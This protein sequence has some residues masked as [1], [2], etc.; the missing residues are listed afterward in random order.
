VVLRALLTSEIGSSR[1]YTA[2]QSVRFAFSACSR[3]FPTVLPERRRAGLAA[4]PAFISCDARTSYFFETEMLVM[5]MM[6]ISK[7]SA[8][9]VT[10]CTYGFKRYFVDE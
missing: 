3:A 1:V 6:P 7:S 8:V 4:G 5:S 2:A 9:S 10:P